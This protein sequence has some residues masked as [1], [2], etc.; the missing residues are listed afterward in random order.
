MSDPSVCAKCGHE[1]EPFENFCGHLINGEIVSYCM[2]CDDQLFGGLPEGLEIWQWG[3]CL[4]HPE[5]NHPEQL[6]L[7]LNYD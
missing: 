1:Q 7:E 4:S 6:V 5:K 2:D 3:K